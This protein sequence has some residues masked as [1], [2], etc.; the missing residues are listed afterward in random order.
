MY[1]N[2]CN[3]DKYIEVKYMNNY[4]VFDNVLDEDYITINKI[5]ESYTQIYVN[6]NTFEN[7]ILKQNKN[8]TMTNNF[9][10]DFD[11]EENDKNIFSQI[12]NYEEDNKANNP[13]KL[14]EKPINFAEIN[15]D[16]DD[17]SEEPADED[18]DGNESDEDINTQITE[19]KEELTMIETEINILNNIICNMMSSNK[20]FT[21][22]LHKLKTH[23]Y[24]KKNCDTLMNN[25]KKLTERK[26]IL[27]TTINDIYKLMK[28]YEK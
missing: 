22:N 9:E 15:N 25:I 1:N 2:E 24:N 4:I 5:D 19:Y 20:I 28:T 11:L 10:C 13:D 16:K 12:L 18:D 6:S 3:N 23:L 14:L 17:S 26:K 8:E 7:G 21:F 27:E